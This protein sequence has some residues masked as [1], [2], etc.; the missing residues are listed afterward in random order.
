MKSFRKSNVASWMIRSISEITVFGPSH[1]EEVAERRAKA[2]P[3][4]DSPEA[5]NLV[6]RP[7]VEYFNRVTRNCC[8]TGR[9]TVDAAL[10]MTWQKQM[11]MEQDGRV[12]YQTLQRAKAEAKKEKDKVQA[13]QAEIEQLP[14]AAD[15]F[16]GIA[17]LPVVEK[18]L[19]VHDIHT[20]AAI[21]CG[22]YRL[23][24]HIR[25]APRRV[26]VYYIAY[27]PNAKRA[28]FVVGPKALAT[29][30]AEHTELM[31]VAGNFFGVFGVQPHEVSA[32]QIGHFALQGNWE[33]ML[34]AWSN[35]WREALKSPTWWLQAIGATAGATIAGRSAAATRLEL[36]AAEAEHAAKAKAVELEAADGGHSLT[37]HGPEVSDAHLEARVKTGYA[38]PDAAGNRVFSPTPAST[39][40]KDHQTWLETRQKALETIAKKEGIDLSKPPPPGTETT[41][42]GTV[43]HHRPIDEG[44]IAKQE[45][46]HKIPHPR[47]GKLSR[48]HSSTQAVAGITRTR[49]IVQWDGHQWKVTQ[50]FP[51]ATGWDNATGTYLDAAE[52]SVP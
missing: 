50:H 33:A 49:T 17:L 12:S 24:P 39:R 32:A 2:K 8:A 43:E 26:I 28:E 34:E 52:F 1:E 25:D 30:R 23:V 7:Y 27:N 47:T 40:F 29:F 16:D 41:I 51:E 46:A 21:E 14:E 38:P 13:D 31:I 45:S 15:A 11:G 10:V 3:L 5:F 35:S 48:V 36:E 19:P 6:N 42:G 22:I 9:D 4:F 18:R 37:R 44:F 20:A